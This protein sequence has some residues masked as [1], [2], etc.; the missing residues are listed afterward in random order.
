MSDPQPPMPDGHSASSGRTSSLLQAGARY[1]AARGH[2]LQIEA[3]E[4]ATLAGAVAKVAAK[5]LVFILFAW[6]LLLPAVISLASSYT[7]IRW[8][9]LALGL[10]LLHGLLGLIYLLRARSQTR[11]VKLFEETFNQ[12]RNDREWLSHYQTKR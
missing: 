7:G 2:L 10:A 6:L 12:F 8:E 3:S 1:L 11:N 9:F 4:S 5:G